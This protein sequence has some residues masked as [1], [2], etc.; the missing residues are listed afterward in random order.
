MDSGKDC[1]KIKLAVFV[2]IY[3]GGF[4]SGSAACAVYDGKRYQKKVSYL[5]ALITGLVYLDS[6]QHPQLSSESGCKGFRELGAS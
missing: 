2:W 1:Q 6:W 5:S 3:G 4:S